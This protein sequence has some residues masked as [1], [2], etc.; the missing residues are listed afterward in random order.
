MSNAD[1]KIPFMFCM[2]RWHSFKKINWELKY[3]YGDGNIKLGLSD[4]PKE[5]KL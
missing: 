2:I 4:T 5:M 3:A 1:K